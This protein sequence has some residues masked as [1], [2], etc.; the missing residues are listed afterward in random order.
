MCCT[1]SQKEE[2]EQKGKKNRPSENELRIFL[3]P[4]A[5]CNGKNE[6]RLL[7]E[8]RAVR[9]NRCE[10]LSN[11][12][13]QSSNTWEPSLCWAAVLS[14]QCLPFQLLTYSSAFTEFTQWLQ[15]RMQL[16]G[17]IHI[18]A[19]MCVLWVK[20]PWLELNATASKVIWRF[21]FLLPPHLFLFQRVGLSRQK[22]GPSTQYLITQGSQRE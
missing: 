8:K 9:N 1:T 12:I 18:L 17:Y 6:D 3:V 19:A 21:L 10:R 15:L 4:A 13:G 16:S 5:A 7:P 20:A 22:T 11:I 14:E 2:A